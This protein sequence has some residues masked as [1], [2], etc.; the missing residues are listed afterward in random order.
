MVLGHRHV[1]RRFCIII[2]FFNI[3]SQS[4]FIHIPGLSLLGLFDC[5]VELILDK[6]IFCVEYYSFSQKKVIYIWHFLLYYY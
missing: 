1:L 3:S 6:D 4:Q 2:L 5:L